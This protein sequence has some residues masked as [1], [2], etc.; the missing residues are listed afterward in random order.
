[1]AYIYIFTL[2]EEMSWAKTH[3]PLGEDHVYIIE[4]NKPVIQAVNGSENPAG[5]YVYTILKDSDEGHQQLPVAG[6]LIGS[7]SIDLAPFVDKPVIIEGNFY[8]GTPML[9]KT[10]N[11][12]EQFTWEQVVMH[13]ES[14]IP[15]ESK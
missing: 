2:D 11:T 10:D 4:I 15:V 7:S 3:L 9:L 1:M 12:P 13:I 6:R 5:G 8:R 14:V